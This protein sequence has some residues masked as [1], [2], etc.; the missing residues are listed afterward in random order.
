MVDQIVT[1]MGASFPFFSGYCYCPTSVDTSLLFVRTL[2][3]SFHD[4]SILSNHF[5]HLSTN[6]RWQI[7]RKI[8]VVAFLS[9]VQ[10]SSHHWK[11]L[12]RQCYTQLGTGCSDNILLKRGAPQTMNLNIYQYKNG[13]FGQI[14]DI[15][16]IKQLLIDSR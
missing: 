14:S 3:S 7:R 12:S 16:H 4:F 2:Q 9:S 11:L 1:Y 13:V 10:Y 5:Y 6:L 15:Y 8:D